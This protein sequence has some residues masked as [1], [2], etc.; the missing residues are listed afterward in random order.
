MK[1]ILLLLG[2]L[3]SIGSIAQTP[4]VSCFGETAS[5]NHWSDFTR[6]EDGKYLLHAYGNYDDPTA[7]DVRTY[8]LSVPGGLTDSLT[9]FLPGRQYLSSAEEN[10]NGGAISC[11]I[12]YSS[13]KGGSDIM[14]NYLDASGKTIRSFTFGTEMDE[15]PIQTGI[16]E[17]QNYFIAYY[18]STT[19]YGRYHTNRVR[20]FNSTGEM[21][22]DVDMGFTGGLLLD[23]VPLGS[24]ELV[25][26]GTH[27]TSATTHDVVITRLAADGTVLWEKGLNDSN[28]GVSMI[29]RG[30]LERGVL[31]LIDYTT[32]KIIGLGVGNG[33]ILTDLSYP[34]EVRGDFLFPFAKFQDDFWIMSRQNIYQL[35]SKKYGYKLIGTYP[36]EK[37]I[38]SSAR[39]YP[40]GICEYLDDDGA[41]VRFDMNTTSFTTLAKGSLTN[42]ST[43]QDEVVDVELVGDK[44]FTG[45]KRMTRGLFTSIT[46]QFSLDGELEGSITSEARE[47]IM[48]NASLVMLEDGG[49]ASVIADVDDSYRCELRVDV[50]GVTGELNQQIYLLEASSQI[51]NNPQV[52]V[53]PGNKIA[54]YGHYKNFSA[55][56]EEHLLW[57]VDLENPAFRRTQGLNFTDHDQQFFGL[58]ERT[59]G[60]VSSFLDNNL[61]VRKVSVDNGLVWE[62]TKSFPQLEDPRIYSNFRGFNRAKNKLVAVPDSEGVLLGVNIQRGGDPPVY[63]LEFFDAKGMNTRSFTSKNTQLTAGVDFLNASQVVVVG[64]GR[65]TQQ[66]GETDIY[67]LN[68]E[69]YDLTGGLVKEVKIPV[70]YEITITNVEV[71]DNGFIAAY[72][73]IYRDADVDAILIVMS[74][75]G[76]IVNGLECFAPTQKK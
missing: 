25:V 63:Y 21:V 44:I 52:V 42:Q 14:V 53:I 16:D 65:N 29:T 43:I 71:L 26:L 51:I 23:V 46:K 54:V 47:D 67:Q 64:C 36:L 32:K 12:S 56:T 70:A 11:G 30:F 72:G 28:D 4:F 39:F 37:T 74:Q 1:N 6:S 34:K 38:I 19:K 75:S 68:Y 10:G 24:G 31:Y 33:E 35:A 2:L 9:T 40:E 49:F 61:T 41:L 57:N 15:R 45:V 66:T 50:Y 59:V 69:V 7:I 58:Q 17:Q 27:K 3:V 62:T 18:Q 5:I 55:R 20:S 73:S 48:K 13:L 8:Q 22:Y 60:F 76:E